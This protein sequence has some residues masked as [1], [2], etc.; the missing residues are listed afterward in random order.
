MIIEKIEDEPTF[1]AKRYILDALG[2][3]RQ[4]RDLLAWAMWYERADRHVGWD[5]LSEEVTVSTVFL[6]ID[7]GYGRT[8]EPV[9]WET[10]I[11]G[12]VHD[13]YQDRYT[14]R[15]AALAG[16]EHALRL[17]KAALHPV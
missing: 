1:A 7:H 8:N 9:L 3:P 4:E 10:M 14:S 12:G 11:F 16:H 17:A 13:H 15:D 5:K 6:G 2:N